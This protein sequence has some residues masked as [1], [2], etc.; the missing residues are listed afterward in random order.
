MKSGSLLMD[1]ST[2]D[3]SIAQAMAAL[4]K[5]KG[6]TFVDAP[7]SGG[8]CNFNFKMVRSVE[9]V[10]YKSHFIVKMNYESQIKNIPSNNGLIPACTMCPV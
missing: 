10:V 1:C 7:V 4:A 6:A 9:L 3:P 2:I 8:T 5:E